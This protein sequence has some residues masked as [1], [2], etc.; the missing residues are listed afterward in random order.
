M[1]YINATLCSWL[2]I[3]I[4]QT[5]ESRLKLED[6]ATITGKQLL[7][8]IA[9]K[10]GAARTDTID[11]ELKTK[12]GRLLPVRIIHRTDFDETGRP[13]PSRSLILKRSNSDEGATAREGR[14]AALQAFQRRSDR[15][16][17]YR[18]SGRVANANV[19]FLKLNKAA[20]RGRPAHRHRGRALS[21]QSF[22]QPEPSL[23]RGGQIRARRYSARG[24][25]G[26][27]GANFLRPGGP[28]RGRNRANHVYAVEND[29]APRARGPTRAKPENA[30][31]RPA[32]GGVA[33][34]FNNV[35]TAIIGFSDLLLARHRPTDPAF[36]DI[37]NIKQNANRAAN[38]VRQLL[39][40]SRR[41]TLRPEILSLTDA[42]SDLGNLLEPAPGREG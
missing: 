18:P 19:A 20:K 21:R 31:H 15:H 5:M 24:R 14:A 27:H 33:H 2:G 1:L 26:A 4:D 29:R 7:L 34:D 12:E 36:A 16:C 8:G 32:R 9:P 35:L 13:Q 37:M 41:Q 39:A 11:I 30:G 17:P 10:P 6:I 28:G 40:F 3:D 22:G 25:T 38:L 42:I 23:R